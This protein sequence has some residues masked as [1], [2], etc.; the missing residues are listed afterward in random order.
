MV[1]LTHSGVH[2]MTVKQTLTP[3]MQK[4]EIAGIA[5]N[6]DFFELLRRIERAMSLHPLLGEP[7]D[8][9][10]RYLKLV[11][12]ADLSFAPREVASV[13]QATRLTI[14]A[15]HFGLFAP[16]GPLPIHI[17]EF[18]RGEWLTLRNDAYQD[19]IAILSQRFALLHYRAWGQMHTMIGHDRQPHANRFQR[20][21]R[22]LVG[23]TES[24]SRLAQISH[25]RQAYPGVYLP[26]RGSLRQ[27]Q[28]M[29][30]HYFDV[31]IQ[32][33]ARQPHWV[34]DGQHQQYQVMGHLGQTRAGK[35][36]FDVQHGIQLVIGPLRCPDYQDFQRDSTRLKVLV[37]VCNDF[38]G[39]RLVLT[40][41]LLIHTDAA[42]A[43]KLGRFRL[44]HSGWL[45]PGTGIHSQTVYDAQI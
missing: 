16:Y 30:S 9:S 10:Y 15:R 33:N 5:S 36:F 31:A 37:A 23:V 29:L 7:N 19:F 38:T 6:Q 39:Q 3:D 11:Q 1:S 44:S 28:R 8:H 17:T 35:R 14:M 43:C 32:I 18:A 4:P 41:K 40:V 27:L 24:D 45:R 22:Q 26:G 42:M 20:H 25:L 13:Q 34:G 12:P 21:L 2:A